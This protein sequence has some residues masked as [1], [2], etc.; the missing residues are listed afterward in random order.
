MIGTELF[1]DASAELPNLGRLAGRLLAAMALGI[2]LAWRPLS[3]LAGGRP[4]RPAIAYSFVLMTLAA[5]LVM[6]IIGDSIARAFGVVGLG[7]FIRFRSSIKDPSDVALYFV[8]IGMGLACGL[9]MAVH[10]AVGLAFLSV[11][12]VARDRSPSADP[13]AEKAP[14]PLPEPVAPILRRAA[15]PLLAVL[16][17]PA[18]APERRESECRYA[19]RG[20]SELIRSWGPLPLPGTRLPPPG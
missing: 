17:L 14:S 2:L 12:L 8:A 19:F 10:A 3:R 5:C 4:S 18:A 15:L 20:R 16:L 1:K 6:T 9:G 13:K 11:V 7:S